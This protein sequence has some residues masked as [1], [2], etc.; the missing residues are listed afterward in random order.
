MIEVL[1]GA[2][3][4]VLPGGL[5]LAWL[6]MRSVKKRVAAEEEALRFRNARKLEAARREIMRE[7][8]AAGTAWRRRMRKRL[9]EADR[10][11]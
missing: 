5:L 3:L 10:N 6:Y 7:P 2:L 1:L 9:R 8:V 11:R 4:V